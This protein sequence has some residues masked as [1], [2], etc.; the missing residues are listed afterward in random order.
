MEVVPMKGKKRMLIFILLLI[1]IILIIIFC[2]LLLVG[3]RR[4][5]KTGF[6]QSGTKSISYNY[7]KECSLMGIFD[8][9]EEAEEAARLYGIVLEKYELKVATFSAMEDPNEVIERGLEMG[10][11][12]ISI[13][14]T[15]S[16]NQ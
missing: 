8:T 3:N 16:I 7:D 5:S 2:F 13:N 6:V 11:P 14:N 12:E 9:R 10:Y 15:Q 1:A 4:N